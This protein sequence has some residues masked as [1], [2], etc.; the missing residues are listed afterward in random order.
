MDGPP[1]HELDLALNKTFQFTETKSLQFRAEFFNLPNFTNL[2]LPDNYVE[3]PGFGQIFSANAGREIQF[4]L[5][6]IF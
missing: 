5:K 6:L 4:A 2:G 1:F 3:D